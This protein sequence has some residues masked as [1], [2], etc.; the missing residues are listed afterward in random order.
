[1]LGS[2][3][4]SPTDWLFSAALAT[5]PFLLSELLKASANAPLHRQTALAHRQSGAAARMETSTDVEPD[6]PLALSVIGGTSR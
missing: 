4:L 6:A 1:L 5:A 2:A 3:P